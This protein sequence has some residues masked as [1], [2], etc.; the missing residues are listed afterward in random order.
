MGPGWT[1]NDSTYDH[2][3][4]NK[5]RKRDVPFPSFINHTYRA[6]QGLSSLQLAHDAPISHCPMDIAC[7]HIWKCLPIT[8]RRCLFIPPPNGPE[9]WGECTKTRD[10]MY[11]KMDQDMYKVG[12]GASRIYRLYPDLKRRPWV[13]W[14]LWV[15]DQCGKDWVLVVWQRP[16]YD[17][18]E[19]YAV[20]DPRRMPDQDDKPGGG[21]LNQRIE[22]IQERL[23]E[24]LKRGGFTIKKNSRRQTL[25]APMGYEEATS[26]ERCF[27]NVKSLSNRITNSWLV[28]GMG[29]HES[30]FAHLE[31]WVNP[32]QMRV[33]MTGINAWVVMATFDYNA[34]ISVENILPNDPIEVVVDGEKKR[35]LPYDLAGPFDE[36]AI[37][38]ENYLLK[39]N[40]PAGPQQQRQSVISALKGC[41]TNNH[42]T[43]LV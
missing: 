14:P 26:G 24:F 6:M 38:G 25:C 18:L 1:V 5:R 29:C 3:P 34:R 32:Y 33:E 2:V 11:E 37:A 42:Y 40:I 22:K 4:Q 21:V 43:L 12:E 36:P 16:V 27:F 35:L 9:L 20:I 23:E 30:V 41:V 10:A 19:A 17:Q 8:A 28:G 7:D 31:R 13:I 39:S 15:E